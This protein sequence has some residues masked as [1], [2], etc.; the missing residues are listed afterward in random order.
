M[1]ELT[2]I[3]AT[4]E[5]DLMTRV[6]SAW[7]KQAASARLPSS[8]LNAIRNYEAQLK[9]S[10]TYGVYILC[11]PGADETGRAPYD[12]LVHINHAFPKSPKPTLRLVWQR[13]A[14]KYEWAQDP[15]ADHARITSGIVGCALRMSQ[16]DLKSAEMK[17]YLTSHV[18][19]TYGRAIASSLTR[20]PDMPFDVRV[21]G[22]WLHFEWK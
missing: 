4:S 3:K 21:R 17:L 15:A 18:D 1:A 14:P 12:A 10:K 11:D 22:S 7:D 13:L 8:A 19:R 16:H 2:L 9:P 5:N 20:L 6:L